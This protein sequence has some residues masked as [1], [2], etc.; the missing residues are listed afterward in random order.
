MMLFHDLL[1]LV[2]FLF[3]FSGFALAEEVQL[4]QVETHLVVIK[5]KYPFLS[6]MH[7]VALAIGKTTL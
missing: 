3:V 2:T 1:P 7:P 6:N 5:A 4:S